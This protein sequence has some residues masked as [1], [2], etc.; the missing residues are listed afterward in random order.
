MPSYI[1][2][3][4]AVLALVLVFLTG[5]FCAA[6]FAV[7]RRRKVQAERKSPIGH[8]LLTPPGHR[9]RQQIDDLNGKLNE[10]LMVLMVSPA[11]LAGAFMIQMLVEGQEKAFRFG[12]MYALT[13]VIGIA[14]ST[15]RILQKS[16]DLDALRAGYDAE[17]AVGQELDQLM[18]QGARVF[19][20]LPGEQFNIDHVV[21]APQ[22]IYAVETKGYTKRIGP[23]GKT[24][25]ANATVEFDG[26]SLKFPGWITPEPLQQAERQAQWLSR[27]I[28]SAIGEPVVVLP[29]LALPGW[30]VER[31]AVGTVRVYNG[32]ELNGLLQ[33]RGA[34]P[35]TMEQMTRVVHQIDQRCRTVAPSF[36][37]KPDASS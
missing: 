15:R 26:S 33:A 32:K 19:H 13:I 28:S 35:L 14:V 16:A 27:W 21:I 8:D 17:L 9:L 20:D 31:K 18:C 6:M 10:D 22:G 5:P 24:G 23:D 4:A 36:N 25:K 34:R 30:W 3:F 37:R 12:W 2:N 1:A 29:V 7:R 11:L